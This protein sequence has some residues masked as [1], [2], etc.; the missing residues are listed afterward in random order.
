MSNVQYTQKNEKKLN[1]HLQKCNCKL[2]NLED[3]G[4]KL[5]TF[6]MKNIKEDIKQ[7]ECERKRRNR[8]RQKEQDLEKVKR[9]QRNQK[10]SLYPVK[11]LLI[12]R[13]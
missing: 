8:A 9:D 12:M 5:K 13:K 1:Q 2:I 7:E 4:E 11:E 3:F 10:K 6:Q